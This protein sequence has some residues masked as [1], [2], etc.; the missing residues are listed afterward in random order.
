M[1]T[2][3]Q[4]GEKLTLV[5][6]HPTTPAAG[7]PVRFGGFCGVAESAEDTDGKTVVITEGVV[8]VSVKGVDGSGNAAVAVGDVIYYVDADTPVLSKKTAGKQFGY[9]LEAVA[10]SATATIKVLLS[11]G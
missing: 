2:Y 6:S 8:S 7:D 4:E 3:I 9:A 11:R 10:S 5:C 1:K